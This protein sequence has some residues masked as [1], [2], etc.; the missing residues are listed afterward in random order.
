MKKKLGGIF[1]TTAMAGM[2]TITAI[3]SQGQWIQ[4][5]GRWWYDNGDGSY[6]H[7]G[8]HWVDGNYD[9]TAECY[10]FD[11]EGWLL[12]NGTT[13]DG[14]TVDANG[15][16][17]EGNVVQ[18]KTVALTS[19]Q[20][21]TATT[22]QDEFT[23]AFALRNKINDDSLTVTKNADGTYRFVKLVNGI[24]QYDL[25]A[26]KG[27][28]IDN[29]MFMFG[30]DEVRFTDVA[31]G[32][33]IFSYYYYDSP[34]YSEIRIGSDHWSV[35]PDYA[36][37]DALKANRKF[38][39]TFFLT[40]DPD[41]IYSQLKVTKKSGNT[42]NFKFVSNGEV[43]QEYDAVPKTE[44]YVSDGSIYDCVEF[45]D[46]ADGFYRIRFELPKTDDNYS[47]CI[48]GDG[49]LEVWEPANK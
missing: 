25:T 28:R 24:V 49:W 3:A 39:G 31:T 38:D 14:Y 12:V 34:T 21:T 43:W 30:A 7:S 18:T 44:P 16:W 5:G 10:Y 46:K 36:K 27:E 33:W 13:P 19:A 42:Y 47:Y 9:G 15:A 35:K 26:T 48:N 6:K 41:G 8:W 29:S 40:T 20:T 17:V 22:Q 37:L 2:M 32:N 45:Y 23:G 1:L 4:S 11:N